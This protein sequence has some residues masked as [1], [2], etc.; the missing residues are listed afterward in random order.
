[1]STGLLKYRIST[2]HLNNHSIRLTPNN[3]FGTIPIHPSPCGITGNLRIQ[4]YFEGKTK[5]E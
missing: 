4:S 1:M 2:D 3:I 5:D